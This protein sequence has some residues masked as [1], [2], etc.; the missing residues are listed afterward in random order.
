MSSLGSRAPLRFAG[1]KGE[2][3][4]DNDLLPAAAGRPLYCFRV[5]VFILDVA[6]V[7]LNIKGYCTNGQLYSRQS[8]EYINCTT[9][10]L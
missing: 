2:G 9:L 8:F 1:D 7:S 3:K 10:V 6:I 5:L 4:K